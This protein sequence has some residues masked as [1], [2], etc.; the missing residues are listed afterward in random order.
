MINF[1]KHSLKRILYFGTKHEC[2][3]CGYKSGRWINS[4]A[5]LPVIQRM[6]II[7]AGKRRHICSKCGSS[8]R[9]RLVLAF[10]KRKFEDG[11]WCNMHILHIAPE[12]NLSKWIFQQSPAKYTRGDKFTEGYHYPSEVEN[13]D[14]LQLPFESETF[15]LVICNHVLEHIEKDHQALQSIFRVLKKEG[16][17][18]LQVPVALELQQTLE[19]S[20]IVSPEDREK[21]FGQF[22]HV[23][24]YGLDYAERLKQAGFTVQVSHPQ[25][26]FPKWGL[27]PSENVYWVIK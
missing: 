23:R 14:L 21:H 3:F 5:D 6:K 10:L 19:D 22:D 13:M 25:E 4:G 7:G 17:A 11:K 26:A 8:D 12:N 18:V 20:N 9:E 27:N 1:F 15:D 2:P 24:L 16:I